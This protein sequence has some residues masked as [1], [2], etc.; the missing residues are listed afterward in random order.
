MK[1]LFTLLAA[2]AFFAL[3]SPKGAN[4]QINIQFAGDSS[5]SNS[6]SVPD[7]VFLMIWGQ[8][9]GLLSTDSVQMDINF[10]DGTDSTYKLPLIQGAIYFQDYFQHVYTQPGAYQV[11]YIATGPNGDA[12]TVTDQVLVGYTCGDISGS[13]YVDANNNCMKD[14]GEA[15]V[16]WT[17]RALYNGSEVRMTYTDA[18]GDYFL[19]V[20]N[21][22]TYTVQVAGNSFN[23]SCPNSS[24]HT[25]TSLPST[26]N[27]F[28]IQCVTNADLAVTMYT[29]GF[30]PGVQGHLYVQG[31][32]KYLT[33]VPPTATVTVTLDPMLTFDSAAVTPVSVSGQ[34]IVF[35]AGQLATLSQ[36]S[37]LTWLA[38]TPSLSA[39]IG[40]TLCNTVTIDPV[41][42]D[43][44]PSDNTVTLCSL[45]RNSMD[46]NE[47]HEAHAGT[48]MANVTPGTELDYVIY[49]Q[50]MG[51]DDAWNILVQDELD[52]A[53]D[54]STLRIK[55]ASHE[56]SVTLTGHTLQ[57]QFNNIFLPA[58]SVNE[59]RSHGYVAYSVRPLSTAPLGTAIENHADIYFDFNA[60]VVT[61]TVTDVLAT[62]TGLNE[63]QR[64]GLNLYPNPASG[65]FMLQQEGTVEKVSIYDLS[66]KLIQCTEN[67]Q[68]E[69]RVSL[70]NIK[71]GFY[72]VVVE[73]HG[74]Q[75]SAKLT[76]N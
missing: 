30:R 17:V 41:S 49:F 50:N 62:S 5:W 60:A 63:V 36:V 27:D 42:G 34:T 59:S 48:G 21:G 53:L 71:A 72:Q 39:T 4:A 22:F 57:F 2:L 52:A 38:V 40:D 9:G 10:G 45:V 12:D 44:D 1:K 3:V 16:R 61:N 33:C 25:V 6:C 68:A 35:N 26:G 47:K 58:A 8:A 67:V 64:S 28:G 43:A 37:W 54:L 11:Q 69:E 76:V 65:Y 19:H 74:K 24:T 15:P 51:N 23:V 29:P 66:G 75:Y 46:P 73:S 7:T 20:P 32:N 18:N 55:G 14:P 31:L 70:K 56:Y 13:I